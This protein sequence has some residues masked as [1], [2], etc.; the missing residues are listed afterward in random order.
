LRQ[1]DAHTASAPAFLFKPQLTYRVRWDLNTD[2]PLPP[3]VP[4][5]ENPP[6]GAV[7]DYYLQSSAADPVTLEIRDAAGK[8]VRR[9]SSADPIPA[10]DP[11]LEIPTYWVRPP[12]K[13]SGDAGVHRFLWDL[14]YT[15]ISGVKP[16]YPIAAVPHNTAPQAT[17]PWVMPGQYTVILT[18]GGKSYSQP[19]TVQMD[20]RV[21]TSAADLEK[22]FQL[23][24]KIY[25]HLLEVVPANSRLTAT[26]KQVA[27]LQKQAQGDVQA[28]VNALD[29]KLQALSGDQGRRPGP[30]GETPGLNGLQ[31]RLSTLFGVLQEVDAAPT[32]QAT[33]AAAELER[34]IP[35]VMQ[36]WQAIQARDIPE[37]NAKLKSANLQ[38][39]KVEA[40][41]EPEALTENEE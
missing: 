38:E 14:R 17:S 12:Q 18:V 5:G 19:L 37:L 32:T 2:T 23:S 15:P 8:T 27:A 41:P 39:I 7:I 30:G 20:P 33:T 24:Y 36:A 16:E 6:D 10:I 35:P 13:L 21:K 25:A 22:Q 29:Q 11:M 31:T 34:Q 40:N 1:I 26:R 28:A 3:D 9:C 4:T